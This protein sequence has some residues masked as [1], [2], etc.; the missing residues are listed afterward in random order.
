MQ[1]STVHRRYN[2]FD[3]TI[4]YLLAENIKNHS[5]PL[6]QAQ[7]NYNTEQTLGHTF[8]QE[9]YLMVNDDRSILQSLLRFSSP[10][11]LDKYYLFPSF[12]AFSW[13]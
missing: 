8:L 12:V 9:A 6:R 5:F 7:M 2:I 1:W 3:Q 13:K 11:E 10:S 4:N